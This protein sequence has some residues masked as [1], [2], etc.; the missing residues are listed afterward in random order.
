MSTG[1]F[2][3]TIQRRVPLSVTWPV[4]TIL[5]VLSGATGAFARNAASDVNNVRKVFRD[6]KSI[7]IG[8]VHLAGNWGL[9]DEIVAPAPAGSARAMPGEPVE[10]SRNIP[11]PPFAGTPGTRVAQALVR[12]VDDQWQLMAEFVGAGWATPEVLT[13]QEV[14]TGAIHH[15]LGNRRFNTMKPIMKL[16]RQ[17]QTARYPQG[18]IFQN[19]SIAENWALCYFLYRHDVRANSKRGQILL[20][21]TGGKWYLVQ[22]DMRPIRLLQYGVPFRDIRLL[23]GLPALAE[24][25]TH[26][27]QTHVPQK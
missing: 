20:R 14:P 13:Y 23:H 16:L 19:I 4:I 9:C 7:V 27:P 18:Y 22:Q 15:L 3:P 2:R 21:K 6:R 26:V 25:Q 1:D 12:K 5:A 11:R 8:A 17:L 10:G 24:P